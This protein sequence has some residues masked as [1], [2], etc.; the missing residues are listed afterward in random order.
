MRKQ[1]KKMMMAILAL[2]LLCGCAPTHEASEMMLT[3]SEGSITVKDGNRKISHFIGMNLYDG[4]GIQTEKESYSWID[5][6]QNKLLKMDEQS[7]SKISQEGKHLKIRVEKGSLLFCVSKELSE[8]ESLEFETVNM[9]L[10]IRGTTGIVKAVAE[11]RTDI[12]LL[13]GQAQ[14]KTENDSILLNAGQ[15]ASV[16]EDD[17]GNSRI[18]ISEIALWGD[19]PSSLVKEI[20]ENETVSKKIEENDGFMNVIDEEEAVAVMRKFTG[21]WY[22]LPVPPPNGRENT[23][24]TV[25]YSWNIGLTDD[26]SNVRIDFEAAEGHMD[27]IEAQGGPQG[28]SILRGERFIIRAVRIP[29]D[30]TYELFK[31]YRASLSEDGDTITFT[32]PDETIIWTR[33]N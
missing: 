16:I 12:I 19:V 7:S 29:D 31:R 20:R 30:R 18:E 9:S 2:L 22:G 13:E 11:K 32:F 1:M 15:R 27:E 5:L 33:K 8:E 21:S 17:A 23:Y 4:Y 10:S 6:D 25:P 26:G 14:V 28:K 3:G 24:V